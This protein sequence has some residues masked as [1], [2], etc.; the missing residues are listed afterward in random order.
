LI[1]TERK[2]FRCDS[3]GIREKPRNGEFGPYS[4]MK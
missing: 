4:N 1:K 3:E 2:R